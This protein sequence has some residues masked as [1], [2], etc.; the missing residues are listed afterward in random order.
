L[1]VLIGMAKPT[2]LFA[3]EP[4]VA[5]CALMPITRPWPSSS[6][7]PEFPG[8]MAASV[9]I[10]SSIEKPL[11]D[12]ISRPSAE[13]IPVVTEPSSPNGLPSA[14]VDSPTRRPFESP[15]S[16]GSSPSM[17][18]GS[19]SSSAMSVDG[20]VPRTSAS[21]GSTSSATRTRTSSASSTTW[22]FVMM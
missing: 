6:G 5:I 1:A 21:T 19:T 17:S 20:S 13:T 15:S 8:L 11:G 18:S 4:S 9:W 2:P 12:S 22:S 16:S 14:I 3:R 7:P 10:T